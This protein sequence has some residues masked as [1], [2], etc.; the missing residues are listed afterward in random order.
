MSPALQDKLSGELK[1]LYALDGRGIRPGLERVR[2]LLDELDNPQNS[3]R[4][5]HVAGTN[6]KGSTCAIIASV[7][8]SAG[9]KVGL[10]TSPHL[11]RF[12]ERIRI[13][14]EPISD[15]RIIG[16]IRDMRR[17]ADR[18]DSTFFETITAMAFRYFREEGVDFAVLETGLGGRWDSTNVVV[19]EVSVITPIGKD[20]EDRLGNT[21]A[22]IALEKAGIGKPGVPC[23]LSKQ[24]PAI[25][26]V[27]GEALRERGVP[28]IYAPEACTLHV[29]QVQLDG[30]TVSAILPSGEFPD[31]FLPLI[32]DHQLVNLQTALTAIE[33]LTG[34][35][36]SKDAL[37]HGV[38][39]TQWPGRLQLLRWE[40]L[41]LYDVGHNLHGIRSI[42]RTVRAI[43]P[44]KP[45]T[46]VLALSHK[47]K[48]D[49]IGKALRLLGGKIHISEIP[50]ELSVPAEKLRRELL[51]DMPAEQI[52]V[53]PDLTSLL[54]ELTPALKKEDVL[55]ILGSHYIAPAISLF[56]KNLFDK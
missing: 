7:L 46:T 10:Y 47:K 20:H 43:R 54:T 51:K 19:P 41:V 30:Q 9:Y 15:E 13:D 53:N 55:L 17:L 44:G 4:S 36:I 32:G 16:Y 39:A 27:L 49:S 45:V 42:V 11:L 29:K 34:A 14:G 18:I 38:C 56:F 1:Y 26:G 52:V 48:I 40:P 31:L 2:V 22:K 33:Q 6:G 23:V 8:Q 21:L 3:F 50:D 25:R 5:I 12:N 28:V 24:R 37:R 35:Q